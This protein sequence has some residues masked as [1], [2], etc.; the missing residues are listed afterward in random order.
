MWTW[1]AAPSLDGRWLPVGSWSG[2]RL[3]GG[4]RVGVALEWSFLAVTLAEFLRP[5][6]HGSIS[7]SRDGSHEGGNRVVL[8]QR[9]VR[10]VVERMQAQEWLRSVDEVRVTHT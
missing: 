5:S 3:P 2:R 4:H 8:V 9:M 6:R 7:G 10:M 1:F